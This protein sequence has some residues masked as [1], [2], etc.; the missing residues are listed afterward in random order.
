MNDTI[1]QTE[2]QVSAPNQRQVGG[3]HYKSMAIQPGIFCQRN[4][5]KFFESSAIKY[6]CRHKRKNGV[7]DLQKAIHFIEL[8]IAED[9][10]E[11]GSNNG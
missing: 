9:Y 6:L 7:E 4:G 1:K 5:M 8:L 3:D 10:P 2:E 11:A